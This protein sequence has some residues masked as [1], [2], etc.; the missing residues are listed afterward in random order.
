MTGGATNQ[1]TGRQLVE[2]KA[3]EWFDMHGPV[4][5]FVTVLAGVGIN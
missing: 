4:C 5:T 1:F 2:S 3:D